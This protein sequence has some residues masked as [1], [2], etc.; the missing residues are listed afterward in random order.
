MARVARSAQIAHDVVALPVY[1]H[2]AKNTAVPAM[3]SGLLS[4]ELEYVSGGET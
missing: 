4:H 1:G 3:K 2:P